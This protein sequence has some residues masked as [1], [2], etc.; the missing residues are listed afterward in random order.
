MTPEQYAALRDNIAADGALTTTPLVYRGRILSGHHRIQAAIA[1]G[2]TEAE[3]IDIL[4]ELSPERQT[5]IQLSHNAI[6]G[7]D[8]PTTLGAMWRELP[9]SEQLYSGLLESD[10][11]SSRDVELENLLS[12]YPSYVTLTINFLP[13]ERESFEALVERVSKSDGSVHVAKRDDFDL[14]FDAVVRV[15]DGQQIKN[16]AVALRRMAELAIEKL[17]QAGEVH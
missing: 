3:C 14:L 2:I 11:V 17:D 6:V 8:D 4:T 5:A 16:S 7:T 1:A 10:L 13:A 12:V 15:K 9:L